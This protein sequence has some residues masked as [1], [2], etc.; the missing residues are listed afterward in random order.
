MADV[1]RGDRR[2]GSSWIGWG[3]RAGFRD[4]LTGLEDVAVVTNNVRWDEAHQ[5]WIFP[6]PDL[7]PSRLR[8]S[9]HAGALQIELRDL[10]LATDKGD[11]FMTLAGDVR[12]AR[13]LGTPSLDHDGTQAYR[14]VA[15]TNDGALLF[16]SV[17]APWARMDPVTMAAPDRPWHPD[18]V[19]P[20]R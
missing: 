6:R 20:V 3:I 16:G 5:M 8:I 13:M 4:Y 10:A 2:V 9:A 18:G 1:H 11:V 19:M 7:A 15:L 14:D 17:Y 12:I